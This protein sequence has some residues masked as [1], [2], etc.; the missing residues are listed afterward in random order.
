MLFRSTTVGAAKQGNA[1][2][3]NSAG[4]GRIGVDPL[5]E[6]T[7]TATTSFGQRAIVLPATT[8]MASLHLGQVVSGAGIPS[9]AT[10]AA[11]NGTTI[12]LS[13]PM[14]ATG[15]TKLS[16]GSPARTVVQQNQTGIVLSAG[17]T[18]VRNTDVVGNVLDGITI[19]GGIQSIGGSNSVSATSK[20]GRAHV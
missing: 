16:F 17:S 13:A 14:V 10:I 15:A 7:V 4:G 19:L 12:T 6:T 1:I 9:N 11:I 3:I 5:P 18:T 2:G 8:T 20:I